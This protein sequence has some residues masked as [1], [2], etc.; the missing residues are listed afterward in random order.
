MSAGILAVVIISR[1]CYIS[2]IAYQQIRMYDVTS[3]DQNPVSITSLKATP[4][5]TLKSNVLYDIIAC[6]NAGNSYTVNRS[7]WLPAILHRVFVGVRV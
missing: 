7:T 1:L 2:S 3:S 5:C 4:I 6:R